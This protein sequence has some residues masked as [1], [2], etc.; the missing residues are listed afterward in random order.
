MLQRSQSKKVYLF[1]YLLLIPLL[2]SIVVYTS[3]TQE[4]DVQDDPP[5]ADMVSKLITAIE[6]KGDLSEEDR[7]RLFGVLNEGGENLHFTDKDGNVVAGKLRTT[8]ENEFFIKDTKTIM[9][10]DQV[11][12]Y[13]GCENMSND[14]ARKCFMV[15]M[16]QLIIQNFDVEAVK[17]AGINSDQRMVVDFTVSDTGSIE[18]NRIM[19]PHPELENQIRNA[20][21]KV[22]NMIPGEHEGKKVA[23]QLALPILYKLE[24]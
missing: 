17:A 10:I 8:S 4:T 23:V 18:V 15:K 22:P 6:Q 14:E 5:T 16:T 1:K 19:A 21:S 7:K 3:C 13:P 12:V 9:N 11:P 24:S 20:M 2:A